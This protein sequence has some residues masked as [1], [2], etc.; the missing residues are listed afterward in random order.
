[1][2][3]DPSSAQA[4]HDRGR[5]T[6]ELKR[7]DPALQCFDKAI[8]L[9]SGHF[10]AWRDR[11]L[12]LE[13][14]GRI[15]DAYDSLSQALLLD[16][17]IADLWSARGDINYNRE[18]YIEAIEDYDQAL[19]LGDQPHLWFRKACCYAASNEPRSALTWLARAIEADAAYI[20]LA[21]NE[22]LLESLRSNP[23]FQA[24]TS[25]PSEPN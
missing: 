8:G 15:N 20:T 6:L 12:A 3:L 10:G 17:D 18:R 21:V 23:V 22:P 13:K 4:W 5:A 24:L 9:A 25:D 2:K 11:A 7:Y 16:P 1:V 19:E 14:L